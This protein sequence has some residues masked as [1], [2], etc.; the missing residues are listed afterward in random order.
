MKDNSR[1]RT[2]LKS[3]VFFALM[4]IITF[5]ILLKDNSAKMLL[6]SFRNVNPYYILIAVI[7]MGLFISFEGINIFRNL[8]ILGYNVGFFKGV[9]YALI[10]FFFSSVTPS[11]S[12]GQPMQIYYMKKDNID[13]SHGAVALLTELASYQINTIFISLLAFFLKFDFFTSKIGNIKY[14]LFFGISINMIGFIFILSALF[15]ENFMNKAVGIVVKI[16]EKCKYKNVLKFKLKAT[17]QLNEYRAGALYIKKNK[18]ALIKTIFI[19][20][21]QLIFMYA[22]TFF[23]YKAFSLEGYSITD[24]IGIQAVLYSSVAALPLPGGVGVSEGGFLSLFK[25]I[26]PTTLVE[27]GMLVSRGI[28]FYLFVLI[29]GVSIIFF[30]FK[31]WE[32]K[33]AKE[34]AV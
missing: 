22:V 1:F 17:E 12:G 20:F 26:Y 16:L 9:K 28:N 27:A 30:Q 2:I 23:V 25:F 21:M 11:A 5:Y 19:T 15:C 32:N 13:I 10:G 31:Y 29:S 4:I 3:S 8:N 14:L 24:V 6:E 18:V 7:C 33:K 34:P